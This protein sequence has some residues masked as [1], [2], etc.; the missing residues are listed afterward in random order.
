MKSGTIVNGSLTLHLFFRISVTNHTIT[1]LKPGK[2]YTIQVT[3]EKKNGR[4]LSY[5]LLKAVTKHSCDV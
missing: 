4:T 1:K 5:E 2:S 3:V